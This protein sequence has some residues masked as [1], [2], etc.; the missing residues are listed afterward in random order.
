MVLFSSLKQPRGFEARP[1][2]E[3][4]HFAERS[5][6]QVATLAGWPI[7]LPG[8][9]NPPFRPYRARCASLDAYSSD[10][11]CCLYRDVPVELEASA[12]ILV[13]SHLAVLAF[14]N[15]AASP[16]TSRFASALIT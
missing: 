11:A 4:D 10:S 14:K 7:V 16:A 3:A 5:G 8:R 13:T 15:E 12:T 1:R 9:A 6:A 2:G